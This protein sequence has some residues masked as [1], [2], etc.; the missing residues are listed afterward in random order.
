MPRVW[1]IILVLAA[2]AQACWAQASVRMKPIAQIAS[3]AD[4]LLEDVATIDG[5]GAPALRRLVLWSRTSQTVPPRTVS[6]D[7]IKTTLKAG[8]HNLGRI[9][10]SGGDAAIHIAEASPA[11]AQTASPVQSASP[12]AAHTDTIRS[13]VPSAIASLLNAAEGDLKLDFDKSDAELLATTIAG[14]TYTIAPLGRSDRQPLHVR[15]YEGDTLVV[16]RTLRV[17][18][19]VRRSVAVAVQ[20]IDR[21]TPITDALITTE[22]RWVEP[23]ADVARPSDVVGRIAK[24]RINAGDAISSRQLSEVFAVRKGETVVVDCVSGGVVV[25]AQMRARSDAKVGDVIEFSPLANDVTG[26]DKADARK[27]DKPSTITAR[28]AAPGKAV[29][30]VAS[31]APPASAASSTGG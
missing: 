22:E 4:I 27:R 8:G 15:V 7:L 20:P 11:A 3:D 2:C 26:R 23:S 28:V 30:V 21:Q 13:V 17:G 5:A 29:M 14:R 1:T 24:S 18:V 9:T 19:H 10:V 12:A 31:D 25:R 16:A 6:P